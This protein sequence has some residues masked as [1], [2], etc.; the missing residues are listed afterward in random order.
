MSID[1]KQFHIFTKKNSRANTCIQQLS[2]TSD[3]SINHQ[4]QKKPQQPQTAIKRN[5][6]ILPI[7]IPLCP[8]NPFGPP[9]T[10]QSWCII[11]GKDGSM[12]AGYNEKLKSQIASITKIMTCWLSLK[13]ISLISLDLDNTYF[14][15][16]EAAE[17]IGGTSAQ[18]QNGDQLNIRDLLY[19]LM[20]PSGNDAA[21]TLK[22]NFEQNIGINFIDEM[23]NCAKEF[24]LKSTQ[25][26]NPHGLYHKFNYSSALDI[27][28]LCY[29]TLQNENFANIVKTKIYFSEIIDKFGNIKEIIWE[30]TNKLLDNGFQGVKTGQTKEAGPCVVE[31][32]QDNN[33]SY[34]IVLLNCKSTDQRWDDTIKLLEWIKQ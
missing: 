2:Y 23:N 32:Y 10:A 19:G 21:I 30:N 1:T 25:Y 29:Q 18:L 34:I 26:M 33:N 15:V 4:K 9:I 11:N 17:I 8:S 31:Y 14:T 3:Y 27:G 20:L 22:Y 5:K 6:R 28:I 7:H 12:L 13:F 24:G 16:P